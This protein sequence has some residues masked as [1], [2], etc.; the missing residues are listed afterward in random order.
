MTFATLCGA[1]IFFAMAGST[2]RVKGLLAVRYDGRF[3]LVTGSIAAVPGLSGRLIGVMANYT[4][5]CLAL[6][7][8][9]VEVSDVREENGSTPGTV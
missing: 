1:G 8:H 4:D 5:F 9:V 6:Q 3:K 2:I 7:G